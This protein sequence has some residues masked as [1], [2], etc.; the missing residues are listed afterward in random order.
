MNLFRKIKERFQKNEVLDRMMDDLKDLDEVL[1]EKRLEKFKEI[2][3]P[4]FAKIGLTNWNGKYIWYSDFNEFGIKHV[5]EY[6]VFKFYGGSFSYGNCFYSVPTISGRK[7]LINHR[8]DKSTKIHFYRR[9]DGWQ[10]MIETNVRYDPDQISTINEHK[11]VTSLEDVLKRNLPKLKEWFENHNTIEQNMAALKKD[12][13]NP[14]F[15]FGK[16][17]ISCEYIL[18]FLYKQKED[19]KSAEYWIEN[20]LDKNYNNLVEKELLMKRIK[21]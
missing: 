21:N 17:I 13:E 11:F 3:T 12:I 9:L 4:E 14:P 15:E 10:K 6:N 5:I 1:L 7:K 19:I 18:S 2:V 20:H 8:T 16:R